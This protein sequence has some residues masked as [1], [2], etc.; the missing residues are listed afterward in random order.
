MTRILLI[1][2]AHSVANERGILA[3]RSPGVALTAKG[4]EQAKA[5][6]DRLTDVAISKV[7]ISPLERCHMTI[8]PLL[9]TFSAKNR[10]EVYTT[11]DLTEVDY[12]SWTGKK[13]SS[14]YKQ[15]LWKVVQDRASEMNF[16][17]GESLAQ[18]QVRAM[19]ALSLAAS[20]A[21]GTQI[22]VSHGDVLKSIVAGILKTDL[23]N[24]QRIIIDPASI[25]VIE[26]DGASYRLISLNNTLAPISE[27]AKSSGK[28]KV[29]ALIGGGS[30]RNR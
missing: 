14:L 11:D 20:A 2:H 7:W 6:A 13:L 12:G 1:R 9:K 30:G 26:Y 3:G 23:D 16:P 10:P 18:M 29:R 24:F 4:E 17:E 28:G 8:A 22:L 27:L 5:L 19:R 25:T 15:K 21:G